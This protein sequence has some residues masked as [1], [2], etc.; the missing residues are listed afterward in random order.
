MRC[1]SCRNKLL[2]KSGDRTRLR[3]DGPIE[4]FEDGRTRARCHWCKSE[5]ILNMKFEMA[6]PVREER[7]FI[8]AKS[9]T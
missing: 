7:F 1:P 9:K 8:K 2:Q 6:E 4:V 3:L 5:V